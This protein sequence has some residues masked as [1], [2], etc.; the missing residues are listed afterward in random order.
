MK[1]MRMPLRSKSAAACL[2]S[3]SDRNE[4]S[5]PFE[6]GTSRNSRNCILYCLAK[7]IDA[8][9]VRPISSEMA[10]IEERSIFV[11]AGRTA[12]VSAA[13]KR[14]RLVIN[15]N[16]NSF[17]LLF[18]RKGTKYPIRVQVSLYFPSRSG[19]SGTRVPVFYV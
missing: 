17:G 7:S 13:A 14:F 15:L 2:A 5:F 11:F 19:Y 9:G 6:P 12:A 18:P 16:D 4:Y 10:L 1:E 8:C 3:S